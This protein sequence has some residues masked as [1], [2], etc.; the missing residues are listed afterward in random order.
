MNLI[1]L[2]T[3]LKLFNKSLNNKNKIRTEYSIL[4]KN[5]LGIKLSL[6]SNDKLFPMKMI[7]GFKS[8]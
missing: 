4:S 1:L 2:E 7:N 5:N 3:V 6:N 8:S